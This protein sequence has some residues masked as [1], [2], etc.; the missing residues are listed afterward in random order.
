MIEG[1]EIVIE[2]KNLFKKYGN[3]NA[4]DDISFEVY[5]GEIFGFLGANG[6]GKTTAIKILCG[7]IKPTQ[8][9]ARVNSFDIY[10]QS[11]KIKKTIGYMSQKFSLYEDLT[12]KQNIYFFGGI[13]GFSINAVSSPVCLPC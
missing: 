2:V 6:A 3:F 8:G 7:L 12:I 5:N 13:Y 1:K 10:E 9:I 11:E 4:V